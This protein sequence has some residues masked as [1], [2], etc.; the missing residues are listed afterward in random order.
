VILINKE[1]HLELV[2]EGNEG[3]NWNK[4]MDEL[5]FLLNKLEEN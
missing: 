2:S 5:N 3:I 1:D 4:E